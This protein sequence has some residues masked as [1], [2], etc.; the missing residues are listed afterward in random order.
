MVEGPVGIGGLRGIF[1]RHE[2][3]SICPTGPASQAMRFPGVIPPPRCRKWALDNGGT[4]QGPFAAAAPRFQPAPRHEH[5]LPFLFG[6]PASRGARDVGAAHAHN[7]L[8]VRTSQQNNKINTLI[9]LDQITSLKCRSL[10][11]FACVES[12]RTMP[13]VGGFSRGFPVSLALSFRHCSIHTSITLIGS[14][15]LDVKS[16]PNLFTHFIKMFLRSGPLCKMPPSSWD[17]HYSLYFTALYSG[18]LSC[19]PAFI[20]FCH[21]LLGFYS[22]Y[23]SLIV[24]LYILITRV[25]KIFAGS[26]TRRTQFLLPTGAK[27]VVGPV[28]SSRYVFTVHLP[29]GTEGSSRLSSSLLP[30]CYTTRRCAG[31]M[32]RGRRDPGTTTPY[33]SLASVTRRCLEIRM[34]HTAHCVPLGVLCTCAF[35][36]KKRGSY[37]DDTNTHA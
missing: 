13:F 12:C 1:P 11:I 33:I 16:R 34:L 14:Q 8:L 26:K 25:G 15:D 20:C 32:G 9:L 7:R 17:H 5:P 23:L 29:L 35:K 28:S 18:H 3:L 27:R 22:T 24:L 19:I 30:C 2:A 31:V 36:V 21:R 6:S 37:T 10:R 4:R